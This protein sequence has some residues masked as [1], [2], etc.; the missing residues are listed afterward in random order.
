MKALHATDYIIHQMRFV[1]Y[2]PN[3]CC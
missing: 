2:V 3:N 1:W